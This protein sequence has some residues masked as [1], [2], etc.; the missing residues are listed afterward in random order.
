MSS[1]SPDDLLANP[2]LVTPVAPWCVALDNLELG[3]LLLAQP[4]VAGGGQRRADLEHQ[5]A[6][7]GHHL[8]LGPVYFQRVKRAVARLEEIGAVAAGGGGRSRRFAV[9]PR[10]LAALLLNLRVLRADPTLDGSEFELK[11]SLVAVWNLVLERV[12]ELPGGMHLGPDL[13]TFLDQVEGLTVFGHRVITDPVV[14]GALDLLGL[15][16][17]QRRRVRRLLAAAEE[18]LGRVTGE[19]ELAESLDLAHLAHSP[20]A[21]DSPTLDPAALAMARTLATRTLPRL[22]LEARVLRYERYLEYLDGLTLLHARELEVVDL[23]A[24]RRLATGR[25]G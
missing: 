11:R 23:K 18:E 5:L 1:L 8:P 2:E 17:N 13:E 12:R 19:A 25:A 24:L 7:L 3:I 9:T 6:G 16:D 10:G 21:A 20:A 14:A 22:S 4:W 15:I